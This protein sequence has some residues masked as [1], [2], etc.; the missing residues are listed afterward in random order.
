MAAGP[1]CTDTKTDENNCGACGVV[2]PSGATCANGVCE[3]AVAPIC[4]DGIKNGGETD[5]DCGGT[6]SPC[7]NNQT[8]TVNTDCLS[9]ACCG[10]TCVTVG[11]ACA[12]GLAG[13][14]ATGTTQCVDGAVVCVQ[15]NQSQPETCNGVDDD[16]D[17]VVDNGFDLQT[18]VNNC[19]GCGQSCT[20]SANATASCVGGH[21]EVTCNAGFTLCN[22]ACVTTCDPAM[23][24]VLDP[25]I[26]ACVATCSGICGEWHGLDCPTG[27][28]CSDLMDGT[29]VAAA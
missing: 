5:V 26:C 19:G 23:G 28:V 17:G 29:C 10:G 16:C 6:C 21:C 2:C 25:T 9:G 14:C 22:G 18:D 15:T 24:E 12:T 4:T 11:E 1:T 13:I 7:P 3:A 27:C 20:A 8:C